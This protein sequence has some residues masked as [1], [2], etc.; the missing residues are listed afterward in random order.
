M[1]RKI[2][3]TLAGL[4]CRNKIQGELSW[5]KGFLLNLD[6]TTREAARA[7]AALAAVPAAAPANDGAV[8]Q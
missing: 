7:A 3:V 1:T 8:G 4:S 6:Q 5:M 2:V